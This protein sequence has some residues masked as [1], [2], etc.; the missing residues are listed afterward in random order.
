MR[1]SNIIRHT[2]YAIHHFP[3]FNE[4]DFISV[5]PFR[6]EY[7]DILRLVTSIRLLQIS[8]FHQPL[9]S[10]PSVCRIPFS[11]ASLILRRSHSISLPTIIL[12]RPCLL[13]RC[14]FTPPPRFL[15]HPSTEKHASRRTD[16]STNDTYVRI[17][18]F[19]SSSLGLGLLISASDNPSWSSI[20]RYINLD[21]LL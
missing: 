18:H 4:C 11:V 19:V 8:P 10:L 1:R 7:H 16:T 6:I 3:S 21:R 2:P 15:L 17:K 9:S 14:P 12:V 5:A 20:F 13:V